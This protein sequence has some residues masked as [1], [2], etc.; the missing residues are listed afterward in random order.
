MHMARLSSLIA[1]A[2]LLLAGC[3]KPSLGPK[4]WTINVQWKTDFTNSLICSSTVTTGCVTGFV[5]GYING[6]ATVPLKTSAPSVCTGTT[7]PETCVDTTNSQ[8]PIGSIVFYLSVNYIDNTGVAH[9]GPAVNP[10]APIV[11]AAV[12]PTAYTVSIQ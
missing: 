8:L 11:V 6:G 7:Q 9:T 4:D 3:S 1:V 12:L 5:W 2:I 10:P